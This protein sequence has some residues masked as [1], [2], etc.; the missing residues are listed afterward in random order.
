MNVE[1]VC[2]CVCVSSSHTPPHR[3]C[4]RITLLITLTQICDVNRGELVLLQHLEH[5]EHLDKEEEKRYEQTSALHDWVFYVC[6]HQVV[7]QVFI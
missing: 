6:L 3:H 1:Y 7:F 4:P 2:V 5:L